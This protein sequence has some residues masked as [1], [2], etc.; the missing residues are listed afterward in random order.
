MKVRLNLLALA[1]CLGIFAIGCESG[2]TSA[3]LEQGGVYAQTNTA[4]DLPFFQ[5][6]SSFLLAYNAMQTV[7]DLERNNRRL[8]YGWSTNIKA[9]LDGIRPG[10]VEA[11]DAYVVARDAYKLHPTADGLSKM[12]GAMQKVRQI[13]DVAVAVVP[14]VTQSGNP[15][16]PNP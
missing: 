4:P 12:E 3:R 15:T 11:R 10:A 8:L 13:S 6:D 9:T 2:C 5:V 14:K 7:F 1:L 16:H